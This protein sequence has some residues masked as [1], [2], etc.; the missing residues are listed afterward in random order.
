MKP[1]SSSRQ[2]NLALSV[3][4]YRYVP[5][6]IVWLDDLRDDVLKMKHRRELWN[7]EKI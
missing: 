5:K 4:R 3:S 1:K 6:H 7:Q 2:L